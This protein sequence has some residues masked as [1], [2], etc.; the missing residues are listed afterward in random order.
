[1]ILKSLTQHNY[2]NIFKQNQI[3]TK[4]TIGYN[5]KIQNVILKNNIN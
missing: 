2:I 1:M 4:L 5:Y 3:I